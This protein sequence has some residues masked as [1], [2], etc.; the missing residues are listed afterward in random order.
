MPLFKID[1][2]TNTRRFVANEP[3]KRFIESTTTHTLF[4]GGVRLG[5]TVA[6]CLKACMLCRMYEG[7]QGLI[8]RQ[9][10][11]AL[12]DTTLK[13]MFEVLRGLGW[14][15]TWKEA[16]HDLIFPNGSEIIFRYLEGFQPRM[17]LNL[18]FIFIDQLEE[19]Q[20]DV[21]N[22]LLTRLNRELTPTEDPEWA[23]TV[24]LYGE[25]WQRITF[26]TANP[27]AED[28]WVYKRFFVN[29]ERRKT[30][31]PKYSSRYLLINASTMENKENLTPDYFEILKDMP[32]DMIKRYRDGIWGGVSG[33]LYANLWNDD[34][35]LI[36]H[37]DKD[38]PDIC[39][40]YR[41]YDHGGMA[42][43][44]CCLFGYLS[45]NPYDKEV[46]CV[47]Y[48]EYWGVE[49]TPDQHA[50]N[51]LKLWR[52]IE[53]YLSY[54]DPQVKW[55]T[56]HSSSKKEMI[57]L[58]DIYRESGLV[59][60]PAAREVW[61]AVQ[62]VQRWMK[63]SPDRPHRFLKDEKGNPK[64][65]AP[66]LYVANHC[67]H[68]V[69][70]IK[71]AHMSDVKLGA[72][73]ATVDDAVTALRQFLGSDPVYDGQVVQKRIFSDPI[74]ALIHADFEEMSEF[75]HGQKVGEIAE[76]YAEND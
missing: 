53:F 72:I 29:E 74:E 58:I 65:G 9:T 4:G 70:Q 8:G 22:V 37:T 2:R 17:G 3:Q 42:D 66:R 25:A 63:I 11:P 34:I 59:L 14:K 21:F 45:L 32:P 76:Y 35:H 67:F 28:S 15:Y 61:P 47:I 44:G 33:K 55:R 27:T 43:A 18:G 41:A 60:T 20:K 13:S 54:A 75:D 49:K 10:Y 68:L 48:D 38:F 30:K 12:T 71:A 69:E 16:K 1:K 57:G 24:R 64:L 46:E 7:N 50:Q 73:A 56:Q 52:D 62:K 36:D 40:Q 5:K 31:H 19:I 51:I 39:T 6:A 23:A 26:C